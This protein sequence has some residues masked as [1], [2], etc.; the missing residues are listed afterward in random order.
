MPTLCCITSCKSRCTEYGFSP[1]LFSNGFS[2][3]DFRVGWT[4]GYGLQF[5]LTRNW[6][7]MAEIDYVD[8]GSRALTAS[9]GTP[10]NVGMHSWQAKLGVNYRFD[11][12]A[13]P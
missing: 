13:F 2:A 1:R 9:D 6:S 11:L 10:I 5:A 8:F 7:A 4:L 12:G 3:D